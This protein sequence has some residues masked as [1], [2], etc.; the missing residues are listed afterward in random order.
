MWRAA[1]ESRPNHPVFVRPLGLTELAFYWTATRRGSGDIYMSLE[2]GA[3]DNSLPSDAK[4]TE[5]WCSIRRRFPLLAAQ[6][7]VVDG[8]EC[9]VVQESY[10]SHVRAGEL[11]LITIASSEVQNFIHDLLDGSR[12]LSDELLARVYIIRHPDCS[13]KLHILFVATH[14][15]AD[16][17]SSATLSRVFLDVLSSGRD[18]PHLPLADR[19]AMVPAREA[20]WPHNGMTAARRH[21]RKA[22]GFAVFSGGNSFPRKEPAALVRSR[23]LAT[24]IPPDISKTILATCRAQGITFGNAF[25]ILT[26]IAMSRVL[27]R[28]YLRGLISEEDWQYCRMQPTYIN[29]P[30]DLRSYL[31]PVWYRNGG[32]GELLLSSSSLR[33]S[34]PFMPISLQTPANRSEP[35]PFRDMLS[36]ARFHLRCKVMK[37]QTQKLFRHPLFLETTIGSSLALLEQA[38]SATDRDAK[39]GEELGCRAYSSSSGVVAAYTITN[40][41]V[42][43]N[44]FPT[45]YPLDSEHPLSP[46]SP[47][48]HPAK[49]GFLTS[50]TPT[51]TRNGGD[52][53][54]GAYC[55]HVDDW[56]TYLQCRPGELYIASSIFQEQ[57]TMTMRFDATIYDGEM[58]REWLEEVKAACIWYLGYAQSGALPTPQSRCKVTLLH[59]TPATT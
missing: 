54:S 1:P 42:I 24:A 23:M 45:S 26:H 15:I 32:G 2:V 36:L 20:L 50:S 11:T 28:L 44:I 5:T 56:Q 10:L 27:H 52:R 18:L 59:T 37:S 38:K 9:F 4:F 7:R 29:S 46:W 41:G 55:L 21:W 25:S 14:M 48:T 34:L 39:S 47:A 8:K 31:D 16:H 3:T 35:P 17:K 49:A 30:L 22:I 40:L 19:L 43:D 12:P 53:P 57:L 33:L 51:P 13:N 58:V 6:V